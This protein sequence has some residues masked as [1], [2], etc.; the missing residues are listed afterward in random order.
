M[1]EWSHNLKAVSD[2]FLRILL[3]AKATT[4]LVT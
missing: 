4:E 2:K 1:F 3:G